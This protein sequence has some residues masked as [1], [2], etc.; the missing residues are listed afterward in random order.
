MS[1]EKNP[2]KPRVSGPGARRSRLEGDRAILEGMRDETY[3][4]CVATLVAECKTSELEFYSKTED[5]G[6]GI[7]LR[8][9]SNFFPSP[10]I[11]KE[12]E[13]PTVE[14]GFHAAKTDFL[15]KLAAQLDE[16]PRAEVVRTLKKRLQDPATSPPEAKRLGSRGSFAKL[17]LDLDVEKWNA[18]RKEVMKSLL[19]SRY[20]RDA[21]F[22]L[23]VDKCKE[24]SIKL[25]HF[26]RTRN[27]FWG[28]VR[29]KRTG[30]WRGENTLGVL[31]GQLG[32]PQ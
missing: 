22:R 12:E 9:L 29:D 28:G 6:Q 2:K 19:Q 14:A 5:E 27:S 11:Y 24:H 8:S 26:D 16:M 25:L 30:Q 20:A 17:G 10:V 15:S 7:L 13:Y 1:G 3:A 21:R 18:A 31:M 23:L 4:A 32:E